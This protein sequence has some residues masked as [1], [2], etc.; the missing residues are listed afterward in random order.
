DGGGR[1]VFALKSERNGEADTARPAFFGLSLDHF[2]LPRLLRRPVRF[3]GRFCNGEYEPPRNFGVV[4]TAVFLSSSVLYGA[5]IGGQ[6]PASA[7]AITA[8]LG[9]A[10]DQVRVSGNRETSEIDILDRLDF[11]GWTSLIGFD[12]ASARERISALPWVNVASVRKV[13]PAE[14]EVRIEEKQPFAIWQH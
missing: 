12:A 1:L 9:F 2:V 4:A 6:I 3:I 8:R 10:V 11:N 13:Y 5:W 7:Q 14:L